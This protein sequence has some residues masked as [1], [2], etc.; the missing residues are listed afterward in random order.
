[1]GNDLDLAVALLPDN[2]GVAEVAGAALNLDP[3]LKE[4]GERAHVEDLVAGGLRGVDDEL[5][6]R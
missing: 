2:D 4:L 5:C 1:M 3:L 6:S